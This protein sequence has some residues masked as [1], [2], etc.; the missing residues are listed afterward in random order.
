MGAEAAD[1]ARFLRAEIPAADLPHREH[2][3]MAYEMLRRHAFAETLLRYSNA[4]EAI[5]RKAGK[6]QAF[7]LT[8]T[9]AF[10]ALIAQRMEDAPAGGFEA[11]ADANPD[12]FDKGV[13]TRWYR[14]EQLA[15]P[16]ARRMF[17]LPDP[18]S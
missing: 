13:L 1:L 12:L 5:T 7:N 11:F 14:P 6:P 8:I 16:L 3:R 17:L 18:A 10:L 15:S 9:I 2:V 4:L